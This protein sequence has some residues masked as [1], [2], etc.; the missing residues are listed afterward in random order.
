MKVFL[1][2]LLSLALLPSLAQA[3]TMFVTDRLFVSIRDGQGKEFPAVKSVA[4]GTELEILQRVGGFVQVREP[5]GTEGWIAERYLVTG[6]SSM[7]LLRATKNKLQLA[8]KKVTTLKQQLSDSNR[9]ASALADKLKSMGIS[10][11]G[12]AASSANDSSAEV[13]GAAHNSTSRQ[14]GF[15]F[16]WIWLLIT[17]AMLIIGFI[18]GVVWLRELNRKKMGG[19]YLRI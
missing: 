19:M 9:T 14:P 5:G 13:P 7:V 6:P 16:N 8:S 17:F 18:A 10:L 2:F 1:V 15:Y 4:T 11:S 3:E 12:D